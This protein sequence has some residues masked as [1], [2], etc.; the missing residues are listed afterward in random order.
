M[1]L[2]VTYTKEDLIKI[3]EKEKKCTLIY[4]AGI[5]GQALLFACRESGIEITGFCDNSKKRENRF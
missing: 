1:S 2:L 3:I 4:G 5:S